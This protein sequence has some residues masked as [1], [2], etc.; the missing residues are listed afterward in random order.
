MASSSRKSK[1]KTADKA[2]VAERS[3]GSKVGIIVGV[4]AGVAALAALIALAAVFGGR[5]R[6]IAQRIFGNAS[7]S[8]SAANKTL[9]NP[10]YEVGIEQNNALYK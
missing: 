2:C 3:P 7:A 4:I 9:D 5:F 8:G 1:G 6:E 10:T